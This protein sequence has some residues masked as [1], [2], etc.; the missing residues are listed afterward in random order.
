MKY[1]LLTVIWLGLALIPV[2][3]EASSTDIT[4]TW[5]ISVTLE[6][7]SPTGPMMFVFKQ[8]GENLT[9]EQSN[10]AGEHKV[11]GTVKGNK[12]AFIVEGKGSRGA[13]YKSTWTGSIES[14]TRM[15][16]TAE[17]GKGPGKWTAVKKAEK[18]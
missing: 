2:G 11:T 18:E 15:S 1:Q 17:F 12:V 3:A 4:G 5:V 9:G 13:P 16:G 7:G 6:S 14:P 8:E 10:R